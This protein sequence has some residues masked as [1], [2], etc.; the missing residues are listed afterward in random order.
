MRSGFRS[1]QTGLLTEESETSSPET[2]IP[3]RE[4]RLGSRKSGFRTGQGA[5]QIRNPL[6]SGKNRSQS[7]LAHEMF[8]AAVWESKMGR[9]SSNLCHCCGVLVAAALRNQHSKN[10]AAPPTPKQ[11]HR[12]RNSNGQAVPPRPGS[13]ARQNRAC[14]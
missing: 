10:T 12:Q 5:L 1:R 8:S 7:L 6:F 9:E 2:G 13:V 14:D 3:R 4:S 11:C